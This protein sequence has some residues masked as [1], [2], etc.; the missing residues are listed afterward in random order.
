MA[1]IMRRAKETI[2]K[3][4]ADI[5]AFIERAKASLPEKYVP[6]MVDEMIGALERTEN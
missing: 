2:A 1:K 4:K 5:K 3:A 6:K